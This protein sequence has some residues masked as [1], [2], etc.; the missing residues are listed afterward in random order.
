MTK[1]LKKLLI[2]IYDLPMEKQRDVLD[3]SIIDWM[4]VSDNKQIDD[5]CI[6]GVQI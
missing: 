6:F 4:N 3:Q 1:S 5:I 2:S